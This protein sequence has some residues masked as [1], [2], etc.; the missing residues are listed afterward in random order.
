MHG[1]RRETYLINGLWSAKAEKGG[2]GGK[3]QRRQCKF[4]NWLPN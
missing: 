1:R 4:S 2:K 3:A